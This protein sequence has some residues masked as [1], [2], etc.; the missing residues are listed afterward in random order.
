MLIVH[1]CMSVLLSINPT[2]PNC[3]LNF[4]PGQWVSMDLCQYHTMFSHAQV[5]DDKTK[6]WGYYLSWVHKS[7]FWTDLWH[8]GHLVWQCAHN[9]SIYLDLLGAGAWQKIIQIFNIGWRVW[10][11]ALQVQGK[12]IS[13]SYH[14]EKIKYANQARLSQQLISS[15]PD[16]FWEFLQGTIRKHYWY[17]SVS[18]AIIQIRNLYIDYA[19]KGVL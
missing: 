18:T 15:K 8:C 12:Q 1:N 9:I 14:S 2:P 13:N 19:M 11:W 3:C 17:E 4:N 5:R 16:Y 10:H 6:E 7:G